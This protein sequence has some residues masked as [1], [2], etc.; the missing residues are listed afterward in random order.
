[1]TS[2]LESCIQPAMHVTEN[3]AVFLDDNNQTLTDLNNCAWTNPTPQRCK[4]YTY[5][6][7]HTYI[8]Y[9]DTY[10]HTWRMNEWMSLCSPPL[11]ETY[12][13]GAVCPSLCLLIQF[14]FK[15]KLTRSEWWQHVS[16]GWRP[17]PGTRHTDLDL[18]RKD[19]HY[20]HSSCRWRTVEWSWSVADIDQWSAGR[21]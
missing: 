21:W 9:I 4:G 11:I 7:T 8:A 17:S 18:E 5:I 3:V 13:E 10:I 1:M 15:K 6:H 12:R 2:C 14:S 20:V 16:T 19:W